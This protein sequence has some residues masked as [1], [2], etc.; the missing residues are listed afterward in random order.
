[1]NIYI[2][3]CI[4]VYTHTHI[5]NVCICWKKDYSI[6]NTGHSKKDNRVLN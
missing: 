4:L 2:Y 6:Y 3:V 1:M 5:Y